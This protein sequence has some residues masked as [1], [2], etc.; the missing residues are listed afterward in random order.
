MQ[1]SV[2]QNE[3][4]PL[5]FLFFVLFVLFLQF[6]RYQLILH[7]HMSAEWQGSSLATLLIFAKFIKYLRIIFLAKMNYIIEVFGQTLEQ[8]SSFTT[9][10]RVGK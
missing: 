5:I 6:S 7:G 10:S 1:V 4:N 9:I 8:H 2:A 3:L